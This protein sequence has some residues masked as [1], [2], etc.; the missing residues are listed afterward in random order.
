MYFFSQSNLILM[1]QDIV[2]SLDSSQT[3]SQVLKCHVCLVGSSSSSDR[4]TQ[5]YWSSI[6]DCHTCIV[7]K[8]AKIWKLN[9]EAFWT[10]WVKWTRMDIMQITVPFFSTLKLK[11][12]HLK[13]G[14]IKS[15]N[16]QCTILS[17]RVII[18]NKFWMGTLGGPP[19]G[20]RQRVSISSYCLPLLIGTLGSRPPRGPLM[21]RALFWYQI[22][23]LI[24]KI[25]H[26]KF[27]LLTWTVFRCVYSNSKVEENVTLLCIISILVILIN[28]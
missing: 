27:L 6:L 11:Y 19:G 12:T 13:T 15:K 7:K 17:I 5:Q 21:Y 3:T 14:P 24:D 8:D 10:K 1:W 4:G 18:W 20:R 16:M 25:V 23:T 26:Y 9:W 2:V 28:I 22:M